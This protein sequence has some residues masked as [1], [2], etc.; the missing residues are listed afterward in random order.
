MPLSEHT[1]SRGGKLSQESTILDALPPQFVYKDSQE[2]FE[3]TVKTV[4]FTDPIQYFDDLGRELLPLLTEY[5][6]PKK[7]FLRG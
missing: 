2:P 7:D 3:G 6:E 5:R 1:D 4:Y